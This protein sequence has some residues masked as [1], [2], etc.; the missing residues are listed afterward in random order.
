MFKKKYIYIF[1]FTMGFKMRWIALVPNQE[2]LYLVQCS[3]YD[4]GGKNHC[5]GCH[6]CK[7]RKKLTLSL[8]I[9]KKDILYS[10]YQTI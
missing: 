5:I 3:F 1:V 7:N 4:K 10:N 2:N 8:I 9:S 6:V